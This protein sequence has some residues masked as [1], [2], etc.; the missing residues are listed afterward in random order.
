MKQVKIIY[1]QIAAVLIFIFYT[2]IF[3]P[4]V[5]KNT[6]DFIGKCRI[7]NSGWTISTMSDSQTLDILP[8]FYKTNNENE[9]WLTKTLTSP[10]SHDSIGFFTFQQQVSVSIDGI[11][12]YS[13][14][15]DSNSKSSTPGNKWNFIMLNENYDNCQI[16]IHLYE[17]YSSDRINI[18]TIYYGTTSGIMMNYLRQEGPQLIVSITM[19]LFGVILSIF[20]IMYKRKTGFEQS[21]LWLA[22]FAVFRGLWTFIESNVYSFT[23]SHLLLVSQISYMCLKLASVTFLQFVNTAFHNGN[24]KVLK[25]FVIFSIA[26]F[27][28]SA[29]CQFILGIDFARTVF[30]TH[31]ILLVG[32]IYAC[33]SSIKLQRE[34]SAQAQLIELQPSRQR[35]VYV[36]HV[37]CSLA[38]VLTSFGDLIRYYFAP[39]PDVAKLSRWGDLIYVSV[40][41][42]NSFLNFVSLLRMGHQ[43]EQI[44]EEASI[45]PLTK[46]LNRSAFEHDIVQGNK[47]Q[48][49]HQSIIMI[50]LNNLKIFNDKHG[51]GMGDYY[52]II[53]SEIIRDAFAQWGTAYRI[54]GDEFCIIAH[55]FTIEDFIEVRTS[56]EKYIGDLKMPSEDLHMGISAGYAAFNPNLDYNLRDT[57]KRADDLMYQRKM[58]IKSH[59][60]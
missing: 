21:L 60:V 42:I 39:S 30:I 37:I 24:S 59:S 50:D 55:D 36:S 34:H 28:L 51:H 40:I 15:P 52:I 3:I 25:V 29:C 12:V 46:L 35:N 2:I 38:I 45:D 1:L 48:W 19:I 33:I 11:E 32:G 10:G 14:K 9:I 53:S 4:D 16:T 57:M 22:L 41:S 18:P 8:N 7:Y 13:F 44:K 27:W 17:C 6:S 58:E 43:A 56:I 5:N 49:S 54:G 31:A 20:C 23:I 47:R 26:D